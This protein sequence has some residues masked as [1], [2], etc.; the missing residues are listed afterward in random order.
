MDAAAVKRTLRLL[1]HNAK[2]VRNGNWY[3][4]PCPFARWKHPKG[5][6]R[7]PSFGIVANDTG[8]SIYH[9]F[10]CKSKGT[11]QMLWED[12]E[13]YTGEDYSQHID[14]ARDTE[15]FGSRIPKWGNPDFDQY[16]NLG[17][18]I[19]EE[20]AIVYEQATG[21]GIALRYLLSRGISEQT[22]REVRLRYDFD[23]GHGVQRVLFDVRDRSNRLFGF[24]GRAISRDVEPR[25]RDYYG[26]DKRLLLLGENY[27]TGSAG[28][29]RG[30]LGERPVVIVEGPFDWLK[31]RQAGYD[32]LAVMHSGLTPEQARTV[33]RIGRPIVLMYDN[34][35]AGQKGK[36]IAAAALRRHVPVSVAPY[37]RGATDP[38]SMPTWQLDRSIRRAKLWLPPA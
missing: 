19:A 14:D 2:V 23:D 37:P 29:D 36:D 12:L 35:E 18:P 13:D 28:D 21:N 16:G 5:S 15:L 6:D 22:A 9:C 32:G 8:T 27:C 10:T 26:L 31:V 7:N 25:V 30:H 34:D 11:V 38:G 24:T 20:I 4:A 17:R 3:Q 1:S 33:R